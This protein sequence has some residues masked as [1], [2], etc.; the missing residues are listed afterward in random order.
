MIAAAPSA[1]RPRMFGR[2]PTGPSVAWSWADEQLRTARNYWVATASRS[3]GPHTRPFWGCWTAPNFEFSTGSRTIANVSAN[4]Q[5]SI[6]LESGEDV[7]I[8]EGAA[9]VVLEPARLQRFVLTY[10]AKYSAR[11]EVRGRE[12]GDD[13][14]G[15]GGVVVV[16]AEVVYGWQASVE[17]ATRWDLPRST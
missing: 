6:H 15:T 5:V 9:R 11:L 14:H 17:T 7:V 3:G 8:L 12:V 16:R 10:N 2:R 4:P 1:S 13:T